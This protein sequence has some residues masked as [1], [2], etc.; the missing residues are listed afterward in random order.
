MRERR[1]CGEVIVED[2]YGFISCYDAQLTEPEPGNRLL[3]VT[4]PSAHF[5]CSA[6]GEKRFCPISCTFG[7]TNVTI[8]NT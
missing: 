3:G 1:V 7:G 8:S 4:E 2:D 6:P 5:T